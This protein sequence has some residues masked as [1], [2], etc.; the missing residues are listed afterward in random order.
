MVANKTPFTMINYVYTMSGVLA[1][2][3]LAFFFFLITTNQKWK[4]HHRFV[5]RLLLMSFLY[6]RMGMPA[7]AALFN[8]QIAP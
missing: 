5:Q 6:S 4:E 3:S 8:L 7:F 2:E 1:S